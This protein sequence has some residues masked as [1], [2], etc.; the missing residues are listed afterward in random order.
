MILLRFLFRELR[1]ERRFTLFFLLNLTL[2]LAAF[3]SLE[4][5]KGSFDR[6]FI[7][8][9]KTLLTADI[10]ISARRPLTAK[11]RQLIAKDVESAETSSVI[12]MFSMLSANDLS[13]LVQLRVINANYPLY[14][15]LTLR[16]QG[17]KDKSI[18]G[19]LFSHNNVWVSP[20]ILLQ[21]QLAIGDTL[22][23]GAMEF[24]ITDVIDTDNSI[25]LGR[26]ALAPRIYLSHTALKATQLMAFGSTAYYKEYFRFPSHID[27]KAIN[28]RWHKNLDDPAISVRAYFA[29]EQRVSRLQ[30]YL[31][32]YLGL[33][34]MVALFLS[35]LGTAFLFRSYLQQKRKEIAILKALGTNQNQL[36]ALYCLQ[37]ILLSTA[38]TLLAFGVNFAILPLF[39]Y[40]YANLGIP[41]PTI[42][43][44]PKELITV[45]LIA[46]ISSLSSSFPV[47]RKYLKAKANSLFQEESFARTTLT[48]AW[49]EYLFYLPALLFFWLLAVN[50]SHSVLTGSGFM[51]FMLVA[52]ILLSFLY[53]II[54]HK[55]PY[56]AFTQNMLFKSIIRN[57]R[58]KYVVSFSAFLAL[59]LASC[60][61]NIIP[62]IE[63]IISY[64][65]R[66]DNGSKIPDLFLFDIQEQQLPS[67][68]QK[69][70]GLGYEL[71]YLSPL[72]RARLVAVN[73]EKFEKKL[74][75]QKVLTREEQTESRFRNRG[76]NLTYRNTLT[77]SETLYKGKQFSQESF[78]SQTSK[79]PEI[80]LEYRFARRLGLN[81]GDLLTFDLQGVAINGIVVNLR[82]I[83]WT[84]FQPNFFVQ[85]QAGVINDAPKTFLATIGNLTVN[86]RNHIQLAL[87]KDFP[88]ISI[89][90]LT[91]VIGKIL[92]LVKN[93]TYVIFFMAF[94]SIVASMAVIFSIANF[95]LY[96]RKLDVA[97]LKV[98]GAPLNWMII[99]FNSEFLFLAGLAACLGTMCGLLVSYL[100]SQLMFEGIWVFALEIPLLNIILMLG[101]TALVSYTSIIGFIRKPTVELLHN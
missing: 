7:E 86:A 78:N 66:A 92:L 69:L 4:A 91:V 82:R 87:V 60:I 90:D 50:L 42:I 67:L 33:I 100:L 39:A 9:S 59:A 41:L 23:L 45:W 70:Q 68:Q 94:I 79:Y 64:E 25:M 3:T 76:F 14:G 19:D 71:G 30:N 84:S 75:Q 34:S 5:I 63:K 11:E 2:G 40:L 89:V 32:D 48:W 43:I 54:I 73:G 10:S 83:R 28:S 85:F 1:N 96:Q 18:G 12:N 16:K 74:L 46:V 58:R 52:I 51:L 8:N 56:M 31:S 17:K 38:A 77:A 81:I 29:T 22:K 53:W 98:V 35:C 37:L 21:Y 57:I 65:L 61:M 97:L 93:I 20:E 62:Q 44:G 47:L 80:S 27:V 55:I 15:S 72:I 36:F 101:M 26:D 95:Q 49:F 6:H 24:V 99:Y 88:N 13:R